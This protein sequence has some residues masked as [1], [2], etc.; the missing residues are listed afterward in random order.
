MTHTIEHVVKTLQIVC[1]G[2]ATSVRRDPEGFADDMTD[3]NDYIDWLNE[4]TDEANDWDWNSHHA[5]W[6]G[7]QDSWRQL[8]FVLYWS[9]Y[10]KIVW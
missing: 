10:N 8:C 1:K 4:L 5:E 3:I 7:Q 9:T 2:H 6:V